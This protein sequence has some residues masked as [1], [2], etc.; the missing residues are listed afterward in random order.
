MAI[1]FP[2]NPSNGDT[3]IENGITFE[4]NST[5][6]SWKK[7]ISVGTLEANTSTFSVTSAVTE[8][9]NRTL[10]SGVSTDLTLTNDHNDKA[11]V[12]A[13]K[14]V[15]GDDV[16]DINW[17]FDT[18]DE[19][20]W[21]FLSDKIE[22]VDGKVRLKGVESGTNI[23]DIQCGQGHTM[24]LMDDGTVWGVGSHGKIGDDDTTANTTSWVQSDITDVTY[25]ACGQWNTMAIKSDGTVW[26]VGDGGAYELGN[27]MNS[28]QSSWVLSNI[29]GLSSISC[30]ER[31]SMAL[32]SDGTVWGVG[33]NLQG[34][35]GVGNNQLVTNWTQSGTLTGVTSISIGN[36]HSMALMTDGTVKGVGYNGSGQL[37]NGNTTSQNSWVTSNSGGL[38]GVS[39]ISCG[40]GHTMALM[41]NG[42]VKGVG[43][44]GSGA[45]GT[46]NTTTQNSWTTS[47]ITN[48]SSISAGKNFSIALLS[49]GDLYGVGYNNPGGVGNGDWQPHSSWGNVLTGVSMISGGTGNSM[50]SMALMMDGTVQATGSN[51]YG[52]LGE[53][54]VNGSYTTNFLTSGIQ[55]TYNI[56]HQPS[57]TVDS[58][59]SI[60]LANT[61]TINSLAITENKPTGTDIKYALSFDGKSTWRV[62]SGVIT[63]ITTE[64]V[65]A[66]TLATYDFTGFTGTTLDIQSYLTTTDTSVSPDI[67]QITVGLSQ[68]GTYTQVAIDGVT[69]LAAES[70][71]NTVTVTN[72]ESTEETYNF[73][74]SV[75]VPETITVDGIVGAAGAAGADGTDGGAL[76]HWTETANGN[77]LPNTDNSHDIGSA[78]YKVRD[79][80]VSDNSIWV[81]DQHKIEIDVTGK[82]KIRKRKKDVVPASIATAGGDQSAALAHAGVGAVQDMKMHHWINYMRTIGNPDAGAHDVF[83]F[84]NTA[85]V[86]PDITLDSSDM[87]TKTEVDTIVSGSGGINTYPTMSNLPLTGVTAGSMAMVLDVNKLYVNNGQGWYFISIINTSPSITGG[88]DPNYTLD[89][90]GVPTV[91][92]VIADDPEGVPLTYTHSAPTLG[93]TA[94]ITQNNNVF[95]VTPSTLESDGGYFDLTISASDG[96]N[97]ASQTTNMLL[98]FEADASGVLFTTVGTH[99]WVVPNG[100]TSIS[101]VCVGGGGGGSTGSQGNY[102]T[103]E[104]AGGGGGGG[105]LRYINNYSVIPGDVYNVVVGNSGTRGVTDS[106]NNTPQ[107]TS[108]HVPANGSSGGTSSF[109]TTSTVLVSGSGG[110]GSSYRTQYGSVRNG[111][112]GGGGFGDNGFN[113]GNGGQAGHEGIGSDSDR[114]SWMGGGGGGAGGYSDNGGNGG[115]GYHQYVTA[116]GTSVS[117]GDGGWMTTSMGSG[118]HGSYGGGVSVYGQGSTGQYYGGGGGGGFVRHNDFYSGNSGSQGV[119]RIIWGATRSFPSTNVDAAS[120]VVTETTV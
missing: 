37:G 49:T 73:M 97:I 117:G 8:E 63:D 33:Y 31:A 42:T 86:E 78:E 114:H 84:N 35:L 100:V 19:S 16:T 53:T 3:H 18:G 26:G 21:N 99:S 43:S 79:L 120:S 30:G 109:G 113:G 107:F 60:S 72:S 41:T 103:A 91:I 20:Q 10:G 80:Y 2:L 14:F 87:Y 24:A 62:P 48:V 92:T 34:Q 64:G 102:S 51:Y 104:Y 4:Y 74:V 119:V 116:A 85:E 61:A 47:S 29:T 71:T 39:S 67:D 69:L 46:G 36:S 101:V 111:G 83:D 54:S 27:G 70:G 96:I 90:T 9:F 98:L 58:V 110:S 25:I 32:K 88:I 94:V 112:N 93:N 95:T 68:N 56:S 15:P 89:K 11:L 52:E 5:S 106:S 38:T 55:S 81:G 22:F 45:L 118:Q 66:T 23:I 12:H 40:E 76:V 57:G 82:M 108:P 44:N 7:Q 13:K 115:T 28:H 50:H 1:T 75:D 17:D 105:G 6:E 59:S 65:D 77:I